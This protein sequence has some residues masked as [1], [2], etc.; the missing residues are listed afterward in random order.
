MKK[1]IKDRP[2]NDL[3]LLPPKAEV[4]SKLIL[5]KAI[6]ANKALAELK[7]VAAL[8]PNQNILLNTLV[9][10]EARDSSAIENVITTR[11]KLYEAL[12]ISSLKIDPSTKEVLN[13][14]KALWKGFSDVKRKGFLSTN[15]IIDIQAELV[16]TNA[17]I[18]KLPGTVLQNEIT[19]EV[20]YTPPVGE[21][22]IRSLLKNFEDYLNSSN[23]IDPLVKM[24]VLHYQFESIHPFYDGNGRTG[25]I[26]NVLYLALN[27]LLDLPILYLSSFIIK[28][29]SDYYRFLREVTY[30][31]NWEQ[32]VLY[33]LDAIESTAIDT[34]AKIKKIKKILDDTVI[35]VKEKLPKIYT[36]ELVEILFN[37]PYCRIATIVES[38]LAARKAAGIYLRELEKL[39]ILSSKKI[40]SDV[41]FINNKIYNLFK[42]KK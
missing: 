12:A 42:G 38:G 23:G 32:W 10:E 26:I 21:S 19:K 7:G 31:Q 40:G 13:Y 20:I 35:E 17:G 5:K 39:E 29:K 36:K 18:R 1:F 33:M 11:D 25:R 15:M 41:V 8:I 27:E 22:N 14:R 2:Y 16:E 34:S 4:E 37:D 9:L 6:S 28:N 30:N 24:A 3:P